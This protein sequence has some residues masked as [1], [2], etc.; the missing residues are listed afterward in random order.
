MTSAD[1]RTAVEMSR[2]G[3]LPGQAVMQPGSEADARPPETAVGKGWTFV[4]VVLATAIVALVVGIAW[5]QPFL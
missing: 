5:S 3:G 1:S 2:L 4:R